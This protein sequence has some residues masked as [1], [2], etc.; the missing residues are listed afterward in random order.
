VLL[1]KFLHGLQIP[2]LE[3]LL[4]SVGCPTCRPNYIHQLRLFVQEHP[5]GWCGLCQE[6]HKK[7]VLRLLD[8]KQKEC[9]ELLREAPRIQEFLCNDCQTHQRQILNILERLAITYRI[10]SRLVRGLDYYTRTVFEVIS[11]DLGAQNAV[12]AGGRYDHLITALEGPLT[13]SVGWSVGVERILEILPPLDHQPPIDILVVEPSSDRENV[14]IHIMELRDQ[15]LTL[16]MDY[17]E[18]SVKAMMKKADRIRAR[19]AL[20]A[21]TDPQYVELKNL[22]NGE[23]TKLLWKDVADFVKK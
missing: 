17:D 18:R 8:C 12:G 21:S 20:F 4:N 14:F 11:P 13:P 2:G 1:M 3:L 23:Q 10:E 9:Q 6:R 19:F 5:D 7:N 16:L 22:I 15:G